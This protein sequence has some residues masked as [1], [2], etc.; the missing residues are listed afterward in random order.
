MM[1]Q[2]QGTHADFEYKARNG[3][4]KLFSAKQEL[5]MVEYSN[6]L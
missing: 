1:F 6:I 5:E 4:K 2:G 3:V